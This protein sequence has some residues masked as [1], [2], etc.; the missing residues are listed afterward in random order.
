MR[1]KLLSLIVC[2]LTFFPL[3]HLD[4]LFPPFY[5]NEKEINAIFSDRTGENRLATGLKI[6]LSELGYEDLELLPGLD[7]KSKKEL[8]KNKQDILS[9]SAELP[10]GEKY[11][12]LRKIKGIGEKKAAAISRFLD[13]E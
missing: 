7:E 5:P 10:A 6:K 4:K 2:I 12:A 8:L 9:F 13:M 11:L 3:W 1:I